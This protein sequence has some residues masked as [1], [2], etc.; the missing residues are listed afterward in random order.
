MLLDFQLDIVEALTAELVYAASFGIGDPTSFSAIC[1]IICHS[2]FPKESFGGIYETL[3]TC[4]RSCTESYTDYPE[5]FCHEGNPTKSESEVSLF[6]A[7][8]GG[9]D[10]MT[11]GVI[12]RRGYGSTDS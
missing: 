9:N 1:G 12:L 2:E 7:V 4:L 10:W 5:T 11:Y 6:A 3:A 8:S